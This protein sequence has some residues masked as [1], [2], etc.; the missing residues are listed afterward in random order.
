VPAIPAHDRARRD[1]GESHTTFW[2]NG[3]AYNF[4]AMSTGHTHYT[5][6]RHTAS[7]TAWIL[8]MPRLLA[9]IPYEH[10]IL[11]LQHT[12]SHTHLALPRLWPCH[13]I[14][15]ATHRTHAHLTTWRYHSPPPAPAVKQAAARGQHATPAGAEWWAC[16]N[17]PE[18]VPRMMPFF[19]RRHS[20]VCVM[21][22]P[23]KRR[24]LHS[25]AACRDSWRACLP[26]HHHH[27]PSP[28][29]TYH[30]SYSSL[31]LHWQDKHLVVVWL[32]PPLT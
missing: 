19:N 27:H 26:S 24:T 13:G 11:W 7:T 2:L 5:A 31:A 4:F 8:S 15:R 28:S 16:M 10:L 18:R 20:F 14:L 9:G 25:A 21:L 12:L 23:G 32:V 1:A 6:R 17:T 22:L 29:S 3:A 30:I